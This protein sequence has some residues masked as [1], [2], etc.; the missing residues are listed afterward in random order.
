M[1]KHI[2]ELPTQS[3]VQVWFMLIAN[4]QFGSALSQFQAEA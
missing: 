1:D 2:V 3:Q 4:S